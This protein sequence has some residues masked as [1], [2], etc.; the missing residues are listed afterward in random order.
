MGYIYIYKIKKINK[1]CTFHVKKEEIDDV[2]Y[3]GNQK[4]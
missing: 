1:K 4:F 2:T 3:I